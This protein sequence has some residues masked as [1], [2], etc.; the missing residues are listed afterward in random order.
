MRN[1]LILATAAV[2]LLCL[3]SGCSAVIL[4]AVGKGGESPPQLSVGA[5]RD[6]VEAKLGRPVTVRPLPD[7]GQVA[8]YEYRLPDA[9]AQEMAKDAL[10]QWLPA[11]QG[12]P[13]GILT[14]PLFFF[15]YSIYKAATPPRAKVTFTY[16]PDGRRLYKG[17]P[18]PYGPVD[19]A[20]ETPSTGTARESYG[21]I[22]AVEA[23]SIGTIRESCRRQDRG[24][25]SDPSVGAGG[26]QLT[27]AEIYV[28]CVSSR[29]AIW[30]IE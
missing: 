8:I 14:E 21:L 5:T 6:D 9:K 23:P 15:P 2:G 27:A 30:A 3:G 7:G 12:A 17:S 13:C 10:L 19:D 20:V 16:A 26:R 29:F 28:D 24:E 25:R 22:D 4:H 1:K 18:P 11:C